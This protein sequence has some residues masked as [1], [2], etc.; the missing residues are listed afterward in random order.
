MGE[1]NEKVNSI[2]LDATMGLVVLILAI[3]VIPGP[4]TMVAGFLCG[5]EDKK[6]SAII[7]GIV[8]W[9]LDAVL[10]GWIWAIMSACKIYGNSK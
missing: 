6:K 9:L 8:Q 1:H 5:D 2:K 10:V 3:G 4:S 7:I